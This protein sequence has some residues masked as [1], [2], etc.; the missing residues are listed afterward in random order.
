MSALNLSGADWRKSRH[1]GING[2]VEV[3][4]ADRTVRMRDSKDGDGGPELRFAPDEWREFL[5]GV[6]DGDFDLS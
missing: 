1:S 3:S 5:A 6:R 4:V 2:C